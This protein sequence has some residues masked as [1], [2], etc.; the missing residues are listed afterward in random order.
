MVFYEGFIHFLYGLKWSVL[1]F[2][3]I[4]MKVVFVGGYPDSTLFIGLVGDAVEEVLEMSCVELLELEEVLD[5]L[6]W[7]HGAVFFSFFQAL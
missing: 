6:K 3:D 2:K 4:S 7:F 5:L 1:V